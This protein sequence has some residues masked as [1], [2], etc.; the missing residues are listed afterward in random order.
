MPFARCFVM[1]TLA[2]KIGV[3]AYAGFEILRLGLVCTISYH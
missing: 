2:F 3:L 1:Q